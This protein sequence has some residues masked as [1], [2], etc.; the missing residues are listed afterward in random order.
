M[1]GWKCT[2]LDLL[3]EDSP[4][5]WLAWYKLENKKLGLKESRAV[6]FT[7]GKPELVEIKEAVKEAVVKLNSF[8]PET[9][10]YLPTVQQVIRYVY[11]QPFYV[12]WA[13]AARRWIG[14]LF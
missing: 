7:N 14:G 12:R 11:I 8:R 5:R 4:G 6:K 2:G 13:R 1:S 10:V 3:E 9:P